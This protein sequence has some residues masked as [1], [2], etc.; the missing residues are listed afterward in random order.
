M[1]TMLWR[2]TL[3]GIAGV[4]LALSLIPTATAEASP[5]LKAANAHFLT[6][7]DNLEDLE[8]STSGNVLIGRSSA[9][10]GHRLTVI[11]TMSG[12]L[13]KRKTFA[14]GIWDIAVHPK[15]TSVFAVHPGSKSSR[16]CNVTEF[17]ARTLRSI[18][19]FV[20]GELCTHLVLSH[21]GRTL[22]IADLNDIIIVN[23]RSGKVSARIDYQGLI[24]D[25]ALSPD[26]RFLYAAE[27]QQDSVISINTDSLS[28]SGTMRV[29][30]DAR[31]PDWLE[32]VLVSPDSKTVYAVS[33]R[34]I[35][36]L[37]Q[38]GSARPTRVAMPH[39]HQS[40]ALSRDG[41]KLYIGLS[42]RLIV[43]D[44]DARRFRA[45][46]D[47]TAASARSIIESPDGRRLYLAARG[48]VI[49]FGAT[50]QLV[51][52]DAT[53]TPRKGKS[54][55]S[56]RPVFRYGWDLQWYTVTPALPKG[57]RLNAETGVI[58]GVPSVTQ[59]ARTYRVSTT[60]YDADTGKTTQPTARITITVIK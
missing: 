13:L 4:A 45:A 39:E 30:I 54:F 47:E 41:K 35:Y 14:P 16:A 37:P 53:L 2:R 58:S 6:L 8:A 52:P 25:L 48:S 59:S 9:D 44:T 51:Y 56:T 11:D 38:S 31:Q 28:R 27:S 22:Y 23:A 42:T 20:V 36:V 1:R 24:N 26:G 21:D 17:D 55:V 49:T 46:M 40:V 33:D 5:L 10:G 3:T 43:W 19:T 50:P 34:A 12:Q 18:R 15:G 57:L 29:P 7:N 60:K 32:R